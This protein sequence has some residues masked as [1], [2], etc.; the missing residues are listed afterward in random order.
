MC[1]FPSQ[2]L[3]VEVLRHRE[4]LLSL[5]DVSKSMGPSTVESDGLQPR[6]DGHPQRERT[7]DALW[8]VPMLPETDLE[9]EG[10]RSMQHVCSRSLIRARKHAQ[11][12]IEK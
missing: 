5:L 7:M 12:K 1:F 3:E 2:V 11:E 10:K 9:S 8:Q 6:S 4:R